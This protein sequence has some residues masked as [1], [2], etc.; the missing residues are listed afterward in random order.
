MTATQWLLG[1]IPARG[2]SVRV[3]GKNARRFAGTSLIA[4]AVRAARAARTLDAIAFSSDDEGCIAA[5]KAE[6]LDVPYRRPAALAKAETPMTDV[7]VGYLDWLAANGQSAPSHV[8]L[9][10]PTSPFRTASDIDA[11]VHQ[12]RVSGRSSLVSAIHAAPTGNYVVFRDGN[13]GLLSRVGDAKAKEAFILDGAV[14]IAPVAM[15]RE[16]RRFWAED[17]AVYATDFP[18][19]YD[20]DT[21]ADYRAAEMMF[22]NGIRYPQFHTV[23]RP[24]TGGAES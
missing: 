18:R 1:L 15:I 2:G 21:E 11:A 5:A 14:F 4:L 12:W 8:V 23:H 7:V 3:A 13:G 19:P 6:G 20:I 9:L 22:E 16:E 24:A 10:Q 17:A